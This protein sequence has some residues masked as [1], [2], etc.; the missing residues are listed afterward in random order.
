MSK[1]SPKQNIEA[2]EGWL[3]QLKSEEK[4]KKRVRKPKK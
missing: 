3:R 1:N 2:L 4:S